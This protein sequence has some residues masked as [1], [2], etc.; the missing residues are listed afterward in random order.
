MPPAAVVGN[1][2]IGIGRA[3]DFGHVGGDCRQAALLKGE[4]RRAA[5]CNPAMHHAAALA[6][7]GGGVQLGD[8]VQVLSAVHS[9]VSGNPVLAPS[10]SWVPAFA[11]MSGLP[12]T[13]ICL[14]RKV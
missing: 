10:R 3:R 4:M 9:R 7:R 11:W 14:T 12:L 13:G 8:F 1:F 6:Y 2:Q 5:F